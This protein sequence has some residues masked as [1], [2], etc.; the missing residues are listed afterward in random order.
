LL[1]NS[2]DGQMIAGRREG[3]IKAAGVCVTPLA[4]IRFPVYTA[5]RAAVD[6]LPSRQTKEMT[7]IVKSNG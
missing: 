2:R 6:T 5:D 3:P 1:R 7:V 4:D